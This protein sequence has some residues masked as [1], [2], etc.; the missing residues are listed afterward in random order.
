MT[1]IPYKFI[2]SDI[3]HLSPKAIKEIKNAQNNI[4][5][6]W[7]IICKKYYIGG[8]TYQKIINNQR[9]SELTKKQCN[10]L[11]S[12]N[13]SG[14]ILENNL[15]YLYNS[16]SSTNIQENKINHTECPTNDVNGTN[17]NSINTVTDRQKDKIS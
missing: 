6:A 5:N 8:T 12:V 14:Q 16:T 11:E 3:T 17:S 7:C 15:K 10:I 1:Y 9:P 13:I 4:L 2:K